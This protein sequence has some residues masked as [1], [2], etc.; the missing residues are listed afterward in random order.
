MDPPL[1][2]CNTNVLAALLP[3]IL[4]MAVTFDLSVGEFLFATVSCKLI[5]GEDDGTLE[6]A[7]E[8]KEDLLVRFC[9]RRLF[10]SLSCSSV[11]KWNVDP[12]K[13]SYLLCLINI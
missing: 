2:R 12:I 4:C 11:S 7:C 8:Y 10:V 6:D 3:A 9:L 5:E 1:F 13:A